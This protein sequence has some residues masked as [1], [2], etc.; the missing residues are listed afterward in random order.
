[1]S[2]TPMRERCVPV[3]DPLGTEYEV[4]GW[5]SHQEW[6]RV[7]SIERTSQSING[8]QNV[9]VVPLDIEHAIRSS[10]HTASTPIDFV[11]A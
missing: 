9:S 1:M 7:K 5:Y 10:A 3:S 11:N 2:Y 8:F 4:Y 6:V